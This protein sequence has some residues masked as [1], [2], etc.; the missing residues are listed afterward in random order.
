MITHHVTFFKVN[1]LRQVKPFCNLWIFHL[2]IQHRTAT[3]AAASAAVSSRVT[4]LFPPSISG[5]N[6]S[7][8]FFCCLPFSPLYL[9]N[10]LTLSHPSVIPLSILSLSLCPYFLSFQQIINSNFPL[11]LSLCLTLNPTTWRLLFLFPIIGTVSL[12]SSI[13]Q[14]TYSVTSKKSPKVYKSCP[15]MISLV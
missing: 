7:I 14:V 4:S 2:C 12:S 5:Q 3:A 11:S 8:S 6:S 1:K 9:T 15:K 10:S 13:T